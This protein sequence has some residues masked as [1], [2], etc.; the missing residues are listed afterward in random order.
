MKKVFIAI[1]LTLIFASP[2]FGANTIVRTGNVI[3][4]TDIDSDYSLTDTFPSYTNGAAINSIQFNP[5]AADDQMIVEQ[6]T[7]SGA[8]LMDVTCEDAYDQRVKY[9][10]NQRLLPV[11]DFSDGTYTAGSSIIIILGE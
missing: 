7:T 8:I 9:F 2:L 4:I 3:H 11:I 1:L 5:A 10:W 6:G